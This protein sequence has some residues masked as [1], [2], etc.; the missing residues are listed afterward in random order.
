MADV[1]P[2]RALR[3]RAELAADVIAPPYDVLSEAEARAIARNPRSFVRIT[4][5]A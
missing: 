1:R 5:S 2:F 4:R 3:P